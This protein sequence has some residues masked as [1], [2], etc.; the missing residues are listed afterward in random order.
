MDD[1]YPEHG[2][3]VVA[4]SGIHTQTQPTALR[5]IFTA[6]TIGAGVRAG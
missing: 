6:T 2:I 1:K 5:P 3:T 4:A